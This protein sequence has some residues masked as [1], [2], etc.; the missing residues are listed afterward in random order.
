MVYGEEQRKEIET[1]A[2]RSITL[3]LSVADCKRI[4]EKAGSVGMTVSQLLEN[5]IGDLVDGTYSNGSDERMYADEWFNRCG[6]AMFPD[7]TFLRWLIEHGLLDEVLG[8]WDDVQQAEDELAEGDADSGGWEPGV[9]EEISEDIKY[10]KQNIDS[11]WA[12]YTARSGGKNGS[13]E[14]EM[15]KVLAWRNEYQYLLTGTKREE[16]ED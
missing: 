9:R 4:A 16:S 14:E 12:D 5:F 8:L 7:K 11:Y 10:W 1:I 6:F 3:R 2:Q 13:F 15:K